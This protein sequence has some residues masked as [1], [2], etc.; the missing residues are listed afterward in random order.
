MNKQI[1]EMYNSLGVAYGTARQYD[2]H[3]DP[4]GRTIED[5]AKYLVNVG[6]RK[7]EW[8]P[9]TE[10]LPEK[11]QEVLA[12]RGDFLGK[13]MNTYTYLGSGNWEDDYGYRGSAEHEGLTHWMPLPEPPGTEKGGE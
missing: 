2:S 10:R 4:Y 11:G 5:M 9:I 3:L 6:Y 1:V 7:Q 12:Y 13:M 8:I